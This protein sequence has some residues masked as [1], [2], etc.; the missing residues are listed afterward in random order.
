LVFVISKY[1][2]PT[3]TKPMRADNN[4]CFGINIVPSLKTPEIGEGTVTSSVPKKVHPR[5]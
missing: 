2:N 3:N 5:D 1:N 4:L